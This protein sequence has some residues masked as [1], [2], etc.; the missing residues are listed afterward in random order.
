MLYWTLQWYREAECLSALTLAPNSN[1]EHFKQ[2]LV[3][4][5]SHVQTVNAHHY[6]HNINVDVVP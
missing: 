4:L 1:D 3:D 2:I 5:I 6:G